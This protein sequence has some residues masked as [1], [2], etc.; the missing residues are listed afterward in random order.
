MKTNK[1]PATVSVRTANQVL[2]GES[3]VA[4]A[5]KAKPTAAPVEPRSPFHKKASVEAAVPTAIPTENGSPL[6]VTLE[7]GI[8]LPVL[9]GERQEVVIVAE[10][11]TENQEPTETT[12]KQA[13]G[14]FARTL[15]IKSEERVMT[16]GGTL[17]FWN[18]LKGQI[19]GNDLAKAWITMPKGTVGHLVSY[20]EV[21]DLATCLVVATTGQQFGISLRKSSWDKVQEACK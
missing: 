11:A 19:Q 14:M 7:A 1:T 15:V 3:P 12:T 8:P 2:R 9:D 21:P 13:V 10:G 6:P 20:S 17:S 5:K 16:G 18:P 4:K